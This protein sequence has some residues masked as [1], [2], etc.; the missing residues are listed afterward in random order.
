MSDSTNSTNTKTSTAQEELNALPHGEEFRFVQEI[1]VLD[2]GVSAVGVYRISGDELFLPGH[3]PENPM[4]PGVIMV[5]SIAQLGGVAAQSSAEHSRLENMRL[6]AIK[7]A[8]ILGSAEPGAMLE[9]EVKVE[10]RMGS[11]IQISGKVSEVVEGQGG[12]EVENRLL[13]KAVV[14]LSGD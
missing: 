11:L 8:K 12:M 1:T 4:W 14:M 13:A 5:E 6:T 2:P 10:G 3:F 9:I 7:N